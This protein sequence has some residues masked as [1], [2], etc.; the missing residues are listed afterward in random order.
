MSTANKAKISK[1]AKDS[2]P[3]SLISLGGGVLT[4]IPKEVMNWLSWIDIGFI[5]ESYKTFPEVLSMIDSKKND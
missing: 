3:K 5:G 1:M 2:C 4:S